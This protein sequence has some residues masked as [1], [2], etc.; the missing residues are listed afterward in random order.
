[1]TA[2]HAR[3]ILSVLATAVIG[4][5]AASPSLGALSASPNASSTGNYT[6]SGS[7]AGLNNREPKYIHETAPDGT[8]TAFAVED[9]NNIS[10]SFIS[11]APGTY[12]YQGYGCLADY[13]NP[14]DIQVDC[15]NV[16]APLSVTVSPYA[17]TLSVVPSSISEEGGTATVTATLNRASGVATTVTV[18]AS[19]PSG[20]Y[21]QSG[22]ALTIAAGATTSTGT[23]TIAGD[24][25]TTDDGDA[26]VTVSGTVSNTEGATNPSDRSLTIADNDPT[27][28][29]SLVLTPD[30][31]SEDGGVSTA[32]ATLNRP[33]SHD[34][35]VTVSASGPSSRF[36][37]SGTALTIPAGKTSSTAGTGTVTITG[38]TNTI[39]DGN[40]T[41]T[42]SGTASNGRAVNGPASADLTIIDDDVTV[43]F[44]SADYTA[45]EG[46]T[47]ATVTV[48]L[49]EKPGR[50]VT[51]PIVASGRGGATTDDF[52][53][54]S[55]SLAFARNETSKVFTVK[56]TDDSVDDDG[57]SVSL[58]FGALP[59]G[60]VVGSPATETVELVDNDV[61][62]VSISADNSSV[63]EGGSASFTLRASPV[64]GADLRVAIDASDRGN[65]IDGTPPTYVTIR[66]GASSASLVIPTDDD[67]VDE[68]HGAVA[69]TLKT[70]TGY[71]LDTDNDSASVT[72]WD[73]DVPTVA[74]SFSAT[75]Y[76]AVEGGSAATV[77]VKLSAKPE[78]EVA[79]P[80]VKSHGGGATTSD[81]SGVPEKVTFA[82]DDASVSFAVTAADDTIDDDGE[83]VSLS[84]G[85]LPAGVTAGSR[86]AA[87]VSLGDN[88]AAPTVTLSLSA[89]SIGENGGASTVTASLSHPSSGETTVEVSAAAVAPA[90]ADDFTLSENATLTIAAGTTASTGTVTVTANDNQTDA[91]NKSVTVS[92]AASNSQGVAGDPADRTLTIS[93]NDP[94]PTVTLSLSPGS[95]AENGGTSTVT[96]SLSH[97]SSEAT[98]VTVSASGPEGSY[99]QDGT[100]LT[101]AAEA[102]AST[103]KVT[104][105]ATDDDVDG[106]DKAVI[107]SGTAAN[108]HGI[109]G[110][111]SR[112]LKIVDDDLSVSFSSATYT[113]AEGGTAATVTVSLSEAPGRSVTIPIDASG[114]GGATT[115]DFALSRTSLAFSRSEQSKTFTVTATD[116]TVDDDGERVALS[117]GTLPAGVTP[118]SPAAATVTLADNDDPE[119]TVSY[120]AATYSATEGGTE[121]TVTVSLSADPERQVVIP[122]ESAAADGATAQGEPGADYS[123][124]PASVTIASGSTS[125][126][127]AVTAT[128]DNIDDDG[129]RVALSFGALPAGVTAGNRKAATVDL[130]DDDAAPTVTLSLSA[131]SI[132][133]NGG[134]STVTA[135]LS[136]PSSASTTVE[137]S[138]AAVAP[139]VADDFTLSENT[140][141]TIAAGATA[142]TGVVTVMADDN[143]TD[144]PDKSVTISGTASNPQGMAGNPAN[145]T[146]KIADNDPTPTAT[147]LLSRDSIG[148][149][150]G[151]STVT[152]TLNRPSGKTTTVTVTA[153][154]PEGSYTQDGTVLT[155]AAEA[156]TSTGKVTVT[157]TDDDVDGADKAV[158]VSGTAANAHGI[159]GPLARTLK[160]V[161]DDIPQV[162]ILP[163]ASSVTE[164]AGASFTVEAS[165]A[166]GVELTVPIDVAQVG[167][168]IK[169]PPGAPASVTIGAGRTMVSVSVP[170]DDDSLDEADGS[171]AV[172]LRTGTGYELGDPTSGKVAVLDNDNPQIAAMFSSATYT[173]AEGGTAATVTVNLDAKPE[174]EVVIPVAKSH[175]G[176]A[177]TSDYSGVPESVTFASDETS[178]SFTVTATDDSEDDDGES[179]SL[180]FGT[181]PAGVTPGSPATATVT[182]ADNDSAP[183]VA[184]SLS[185]ASID[186]NDGTATIAARLDRPSTT[187]TTIAI[188]AA[189]VSPAVAGDFSLSDN[190]TLTIAAGAIDSTG[191]VSVTAENNNVDAPDKTVT[192]SGKVS[193]APGIADPADVTLTI[194]DDE[195]APTVDLALTPAAIAEGESSTVT[196][197]L[198]HPSSEP[199]TVTVTASGPEGGYT[200]TGTTLTIAARETDSTGKVTV[201]ATDDDIDGDDRSVTVSGV[202]A[203]AHGATGPAPRT[204]TIED[205]D[206]AAIEASFSASTYTAAEGGDAATVT[207]TL[208][209]DPGRDITIPIEAA[210]AGGATAQG[211]PGAD[212]SGIPDSVAFAAGQTRRSFVATAI[213]DTFDDDGERVALSFGDLP[214]GIAAG[215]PA[216]ATLTLAD[217]DVPSWSLSLEP[218]T[219]AEAG[220]TATLTVST[221]GAVTFEVDRTVALTLSGTATAGTDYT[222][223]A[224]GEEL[225]LPYA[226]TLPA[227]TTSA[228]A[229]LTGLADAVEDAGETVAIAASV[230]GT[231]PRAP[232]FGTVTATLVEGICG[233]TPEVRDAI[234]AALGPD[235]SCMNVTPAQLAGIASLSLNGAGLTSLEAD[236]FAGLGGLTL[237]DLE[238]NRLTALPANVFDGLG[239]LTELRL[240]NN[241]LTAL[242]RGLF[243]ALGALTALG[244]DNN[245]IESLRGN[246]FSGLTRL[247]ELNLRRNRLTALP[248]TVFSGLTALRHINLRQN[249]LQRLPSRVFGGLTALQTLNLRANAL[250]RLPDGLFAGLTGLTTLRL[251][252]NGDDALSLRVSLEKVGDD[253]FRAT[254]PA[255][256]P[257]DLTL[258]IDIGNGA[259]AGGGTGVTIPAGAVES[260]AAT[261]ER[262]AGT[263]AAVTADLGALPAPP[264]NHSGYALAKAADRPLDVLAALPV[265]AVSIAA[266][267]ASVVEGAGAAFTV[268]RTGSTESAL[269]VSVRVTQTG[270]VLETPADYTSAA[271]VAIPAG[272]AAATLTVATDDDAVD[273][274][275]ADAPGTAGRVSAAV[276]A[277]AGYAPAATGTATVA[278]LDNDPP[279]PIAMP[280]AGAL[281]GN[282]GQ[283][284][285]G[286]LFVHREMTL[287]QGF[288]TGPDAPGRDGFAL[289][290]VTANVTNPP[291]T[292][293]GVTV[294]LHAADAEGNPGKRLYALAN[295]ATFSTGRNA[296]AAPADAALEAGTSYFVVFE[297]SGANALDFQL[298]YTGS[299][300]ED[301]GGAS[302]WSLADAT[303]GAAGGVLSIGIAGYARPA[304]PP[305]I[306]VADARAEE[307]KDASVDFPVAL[308]RT[309]AETVT[310][311]Y[312]TVDGTAVA[313]EDYSAASGTLTFTP[314]QTSKTVSVSVLDDLVDEDEER[315]TLLLYNAT[316]AGVSTAQAQGTIANSDPLPQAWLVRFGRTVAS[317]VADGVGERL[318]RTGTGTEV[319]HFTFAG[320]RMPYGPDGELSGFGTTGLNSTQDMS[321]FGKR[322]WLSGAA[323]Y[324]A[325]H[326]AALPGVPGLTG[327]SAVPDTASRGLTDRDLLVGSSFLLTVGRDEE[328][329]TGGWTWWGRGMATRFD[330]A[331]DELDLNGAVRTWMMGADTRRGRWLAGVALA[332]STGAGGYDATLADGR[333]ERGAIETALT[334]VHP[335]ARFSVNERLSAWGMLGYG[336]GE[337]ALDRGGSGTW[338]VDTAM[339][340][341]AVGA[342]GVLRPAAFGSGTELAV[343]TDVLW[344]SIRSGGAE[345]AAGRL[346]ASAGAASRLRLILEGSRQFAF[347]DGRTLTPTLELGVRRDAG[348]AET[349]A[350]VELGGGLRF[351]DPDRGLSI[352]LSARGLVAHRDQDYREWGASA[353]IQFDPGIAGKGLIVAL[354]PSWGAASSGAE[355]LWSQPDARGLAPYGQFLPEGRLDAELGYA[356][357]G[358]KGRGMQT[359][360]AA[361]SRADAGERTIR[362]GWRLAMSP[363]RSLDLEGIQRQPANGGPAENALLLRMA[364]RW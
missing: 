60:V 72:V 180:S 296:F 246:A 279:I 104:V 105:T 195:P 260:S 258:P 228:T 241:R 143:Q 6:V 134:S 172:T 268:T 168:Y 53:L 35:T 224:A 238:A 83:R 67:S 94:S 318:M 159:A 41:V 274:A 293:S 199:T 182:L 152:A 38:K 267:S 313:G 20:R 227:G 10:L 163:D 317:H 338:T 240:K 288:A 289:G 52:T 79:I 117:F 198:S 273:E 361:L 264:A 271:T 270:T 225:T 69:V 64:P 22:T 36:T 148:E 339:K 353:A 218:T 179:V 30:S 248:R 165:P 210:A 326:P 362:L 234:V 314:G 131:S 343:R 126:S 298:A 171:I 349:G 220:G 335:Y 311:S 93:D 181:L 58:S 44:A 205:D 33:S 197:S 15:G 144:A 324:G 342:R 308:D 167:S 315:F 14:F 183:E 275:L 360:Y 223:F 25:N 280:D 304:P 185:A 255:G 50:S 352:E 76:T 34:T 9:A 68:A 123:G 19:G 141:L 43:S 80:I 340:M 184:L 358:P 300:A 347:A 331:E 96:A 160:I 203:N 89:S 357:T 140:T 346:A 71:S 7:V 242:P 110:P 266:V 87:T 355:R 95:I 158:I 51:I 173:A 309:S 73:D 65:Y 137:V 297:Y 120:S 63:T 330:G 237:L 49:N 283:T 54:S 21:T 354:T 138:A 282:L 247:E 24:A 251:D 230:G 118:G 292:P 329:A 250:N 284:P 59:T 348:D 146:L 252:D 55:T 113:A 363:L 244:L 306:S 29:V 192:V 359:P 8:I 295:P 249:R 3:T 302:G 45:T 341:G 128:D 145:L 281:A 114:R 231:P 176:G 305:K 307:G 328:T 209:A 175:G 212:Y 216:A 100:V 269:N 26:T 37:Q 204:L 121:A 332:H 48:N 207:V 5:L 107:V 287:S 174:R 47:T 16:G 119:V 42:V 272:V 31:I 310:V 236:D 82:S 291:D 115:A 303:R 188:S 312:R 142:S 129:E 186:E 214:D 254:V 345:T 153:S 28:T 286:S 27:P 364:L 229:T 257:F 127:F 294:G 206:D 130:D 253:G 164:G 125:A 276:E 99:T 111:L 23:V 18:S 325:G 219:V 90:A 56:A 109:T 245:R 178:A 321:P 66:A 201:E 103:G 189:A 106:A 85:T 161:D 70:G 193:G 108:A 149:N 116:D 259:I 285:I 156:T 215:D 11:K 155:I 301:A 221:G 61:P 12:T 154:G 316:G 233:R 262:A 139:A 77:T 136:H 135:S 334:G 243:E 277:G 17:V 112:T 239:A 166:P 322:P 32:T 88:D 356:M 1:M 213:D 350:G 194:A 211:E 102:T 202:A 265:P 169:D 2:F 323:D 226:L 75:G 132:A 191:T 122:I 84:F 92:G 208:S 319:P 232:V 86:K 235:A 196:A 62:E 217:D 147:L 133:E 151:V 98:T 290:S 320:L 327:L 256:A 39:D 46:G 78:R 278:I 200:Q 57:E 336:V 91:P 101:I 190:R 337:L 333:T 74:V 299:T 344:T 81:Y 124:V 261:V 40:A 13:S 162:T 263:H 4:T 351:A 187:A 222:L 177:T 150:G 170:T 157:A 97:P